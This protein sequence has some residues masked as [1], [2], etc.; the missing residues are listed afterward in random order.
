MNM[1]HL[2][3]TLAIGSLVFSLGCD[4]LR[5]QAAEKSGKKPT[6]IRNEDDD[7]EEEDTDT[8]NNK[9]S[10]SPGTTDDESGDNDAGGPGNGTGIDA[11][12]GASTIP[13]NPNGLQFARDIRP[14]TER[15]CTECHHAGGKSPD[16]VQFPLVVG[17]MADQAAAVDR[18]IATMGGSMP[19]APRDRVPADAIDKIRKWKADGMQ[20]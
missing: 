13:A 20:P 3:G 7:S 2:L 9:K 5:P 16:L 19:P 15:Y 18:V 11:G 12:P 4:M 1:R 10:G 8:S 6:V 14:I 17:T